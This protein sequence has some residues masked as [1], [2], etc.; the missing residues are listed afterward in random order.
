MLC[1]TEH[2]QTMVFT[3]VTGLTTLTVMGVRLSPTTRSPGVSVAASTPFAAAANTTARDCAISVRSRVV[4]G[5]ANGQDSISS[6]S[7]DYLDA[8]L[9]C[10][11]VRRSRLLEDQRDH[12]HIANTHAVFRRGLILPLPRL[13]HDEG[14]VC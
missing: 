4:R 5:T 7:R 11:D 12:L 2:V 6:C 14:V 1:S 3:A 9:T 10:K 8:I 13:V